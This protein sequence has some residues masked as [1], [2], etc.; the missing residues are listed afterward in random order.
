MG[1]QGN[2]KLSVRRKRPPHL[3]SLLLRCTIISQGKPITTDT[4]T[5]NTKHR[6]Y[7]ARYQHVL[8]AEG[9]SAQVGDHAEVEHQKTAHCSFIHYLQV[10]RTTMSQIPTVGGASLHPPRY[11]NVHATLLFTN[12]SK[13]HLVQPVMTNY[14]YR[15]KP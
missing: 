15:E 6:A 7:A 5:S 11:R 4:P 13:W 2:A 1:R 8:G 3:P 14:W 10:M 12:A 9:S